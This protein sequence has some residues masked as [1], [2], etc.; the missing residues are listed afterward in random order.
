MKLNVLSRIL[1]STALVVS[2]IS[3]AAACTLLL[4]T[5]AKGRAYTGRTMEFVGSVP[6]HLVYY[7]TGS[8]IESVTPDGQEGVAFNTKHAV[9]AVTVF[10]VIPNAKQDVFHEAINDQGMTFSTNSL[11]GNISPSVRQVPNGKILSAVDLGAWALGNF[12]TV[13]QVKQ[14]LDNKEVEIWLP[15]TAFLGAG[16]LP[17]HFGLFDRSGAGIVIEWT[18]GQTT[19]YDNPVG[20]MTNNPAFPWHL[21]NMG[22]YAY[23]TNIDK[24]SAKFNKL[25]VAAFDG[26]GN[27]ANLPSTETSPGRFVKAAYYSTF[28]EKAKTPDQAILTLGHVMNNFDRPKN[29]SIDLSRDMPGGE[30]NMSDTQNG[31]P[32]S[33]VTNWTVLS[34]LTQNHFHIRTINS[35]NFTKFDVNRLS[36]LKEVKTVS[37]D[38]LNANASLDGTDLFLK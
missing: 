26:G 16:P 12:E 5:D 35:L 25:S 10:G 38:T 1:L 22:N 30:R 2:S 36:V 32:T 37:F 15:S 21:E 28:A 7:P 11:G 33:E 3:N 4:Y 9:L 23:L 27:M 17:L 34:D 29:I 13:A 19:V 24:N 31:K 18:N 20:V 6:N 14:A 8:R